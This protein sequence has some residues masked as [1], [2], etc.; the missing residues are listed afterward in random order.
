MLLNTDETE[1][2][3]DNAAGQRDSLGVL[4]LAVEGEKAVLSVGSG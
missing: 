2:T 4:G 1:P 3:A